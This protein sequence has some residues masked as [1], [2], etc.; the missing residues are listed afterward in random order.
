MAAALRTV[1]RGEVVLE[2]GRT[3][4]GVTPVRV[5]VTK[6]DRRYRFSD[7]R[8]AVA[9]AGISAA[10]LAFPERIRLG[11]RSV[12]VGRRGEVWLPAVEWSG[13]AWLAALPELVAEGSLVLYES[14][15][16]TFE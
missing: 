2:T 14:L 9:A 6:R 1:E 5:H 12:N 11:A 3:Y 8:G 15:L 7:G 16:E 13:D 4:D 10:G